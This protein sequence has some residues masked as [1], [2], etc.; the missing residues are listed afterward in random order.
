MMDT[1][2][3][4]MKYKFSGMKY[5]RMEGHRNSGSMQNTIL[6]KLLPCV[7][8]AIFSGMMIYVASCSSD[9][10]DNSFSI[11][12]FPVTEAVPGDTLDNQLDSIYVL[13]TVSVVGDNY[14]FYTYDA[15]YFLLSFNPDSGEQIQFAPKGE[16][17]GEMT[18]VSGN[19]GQPLKSDSVFSAF[20]S[21]RLTLVACHADNGYSLEDMISYPTS[22]SRYVP[23]NVTVLQ[24]GQHISPRGDFRYGIVS[25]DPVSEEVTEWPLGYQFEDTDNPDAEAVSMRTTSYSKSRRLVA[26]IY[27]RVPAVILHNEDGSIRDVFEFTSFDATKKD[28]DGEPM[29]CFNKVYLTDNSIWLLYNGDDEEA[30]QLLVLSYDGTPLCNMTIGRT[31][32]FRIDPKR[33]RIIAVNPNADGANAISYPIPA[34]ISL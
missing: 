14:I 4:G 5:K 1:S 30:S 26:E 17:P 31:L 29:D 10:G 18:A 6:N 7:N 28:S 32:T 13:G 2:F 11:E 15:D 27:G 8:I 9:K 21:N 3:S 23:F 16:G 22:F 34:S 12:D 25:Y 20:D 33:R 24:N 19:F